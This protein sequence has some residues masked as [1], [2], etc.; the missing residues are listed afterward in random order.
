MKRLAMYF[1]FVAIFAGCDKPDG[2]IEDR[3]L[4]VYPNPTTGRSVTAVVDVAGPYTL[5]IFRPNG[6]S[7]ITITNSSGQKTHEWV[8]DDIGTYYLIVTAG[9]DKITRTLIRR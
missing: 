7:M 5:Q 3:R 4:V 1:F 6:S 9:N 8:P 2:G